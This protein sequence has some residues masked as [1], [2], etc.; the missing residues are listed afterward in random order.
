MSM[1]TRNLV[2]C[3]FLLLLCALVSTTSRA[4]NEDRDSLRGINGVDVLAE[5][6]SPGAKSIGLTKRTLETDVK[7]INIDSSIP[8]ISKIGDSCTYSKK[9]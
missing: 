8:Q 4:G 6:L 1:K 5:S 7:L 2:F 9:I 3:A